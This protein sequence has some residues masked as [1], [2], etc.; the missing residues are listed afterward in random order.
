MKPDYIK[1]AAITFSIALASLI[2]YGVFTA[3][4]QMSDREK[5]STNVKNKKFPLVTI[6]DLNGQKID[7]AFYNS[8]TKMVVYLS[9]KCPHCLSFLKAFK[10]NTS[11]PKENILPIFKAEIASI[12]S[13]SKAND[14]TSIKLYHVDNSSIT[15]KIKSVPAFLVLDEMNKIKQVY[16]GVPRMDNNDSLIAYVHSYMSKN[17]LQNKAPTESC[18]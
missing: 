12:D 18:H 17:E 9:V 8:H 3:F 15:Q 14:L 13:F 10:A 1:I 4:K 11:L 16:H 6:S 2:V 5:L 7:S